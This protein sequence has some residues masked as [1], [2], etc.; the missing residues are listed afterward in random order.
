MTRDEENL[1]KMQHTF[2]HTNKLTDILNERKSCLVIEITLGAYLISFNN[3][4]LNK[5]YKIRK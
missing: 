4:D 5:K 3:V 1:F 2:T